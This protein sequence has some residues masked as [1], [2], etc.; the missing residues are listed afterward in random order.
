[1]L[2]EPVGKKTKTV[3]NT[4]KA[5]HRLPESDKDGGPTMDER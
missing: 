5:M 3:Q 4:P 1:M 2:P